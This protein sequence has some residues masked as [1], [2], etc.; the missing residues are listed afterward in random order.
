MTSLNRG[1]LESY[2]RETFTNLDR[3]G[4]VSPDAVG[5]EVVTDASNCQNG[6]ESKVFL[7]S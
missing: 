2:F 6:K 3:T 7:G 5:T 4:E 1:E